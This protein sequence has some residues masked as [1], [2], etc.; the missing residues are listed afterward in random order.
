MPSSTGGLERKEENRHDGKQSGRQV[1]SDDMGEDRT[2][3]V[4]GGCGS[5]YGTVGSELR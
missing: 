4:S 5:H 2:G 1:D 3:G